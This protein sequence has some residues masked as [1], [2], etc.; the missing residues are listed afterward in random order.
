MKSLVIDKFGKTGGKKLIWSDLIYLLVLLHL[1]NV[2]KT[3]K[4]SK[5]EE[6]EGLV[7]PLAG[8][9]MHGLMEKNPFQLC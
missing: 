2:T 7:G 5:D 9:L 1:N 3:A 4:N 8:F 6:M